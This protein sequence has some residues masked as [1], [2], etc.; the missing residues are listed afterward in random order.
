MIGAWSVQLY[1][2]WNRIQQ[3]KVNS[4]ILITKL[5]THVFKISVGD[6]SC[7]SYITKLLSKLSHLDYQAK[8][9]LFDHQ[10]PF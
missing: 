3:I 5:L 1:L 9:V 4:C 8:H 10:T 7:W 6:S 2:Q